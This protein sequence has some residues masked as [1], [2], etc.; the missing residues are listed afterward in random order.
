VRA[1]KEIAA[2]M[3]LIPKKVVDRIA[4]GENALRVLREWRG[5]T[6]LYIS[7]KTNI[8]QGYISDLEEVILQLR[9]AND[10]ARAGLSLRAFERHRTI[11]ICSGRS[12]YGPFQKI[13]TTSLRHVLRRRFMPLLNSRVLCAGD[14]QCCGN[15][16][17]GPSR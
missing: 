16:W 13:I 1:R 5:K 10:L 8:G 4:G 12:G 11:L 3:P 14:N 2:G 17:P 7:H 9:Q 15:D 6:Q